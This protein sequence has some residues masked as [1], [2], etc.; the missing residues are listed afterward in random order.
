MTPQ[1]TSETEDPVTSYP[2]NAQSE[3]P[4]YR[5]KQW[6]NAHEQLSLATKVINKNPESANYN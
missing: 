1:G 6:L 5:R 3:L 4:A 2:F